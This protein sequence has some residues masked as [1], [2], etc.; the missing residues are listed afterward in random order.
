MLVAVSGGVDSMVMLDLIMK[1][2]IYFEVLHINHQTRGIDNLKDLMCVQ[3]K[4][5]DKNIK[6]HVFE[7]N[8]NSG[9]FQSE[10]RKF[11]LEMAKK[12]I[13]ENNLSAL[14]YA[15]HKDDQIENI[16]MNKDK[17]SPK[18][19]NR[20]T[21]YEELKIYRPLLEVYKANIYE[22]AEKNNVVFNEDYS[23]F[24]VKYKRNYFRNNMISKMTIDEKDEVYKREDKYRELYELVEVDSSITV[25]TLVKMPKTYTM[26]LL[27][28]MIKEKNKE[29]NVSK[30]L[31]NDILLFINQNKNGQLSISDNLIIRVSYGKILIESIS[32]ENIV[33]S[34]ILK[35]GENSFN[36]IDFYNNNLSGFIRT[37]KPG[38]K[39]EIKNG[40]KKL[41]RLFIDN[42][43]DVKERSKWPIVVDENDEIIWIPKLWRNKDEID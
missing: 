19:M 21:L 7:Y 30:S 14:V 41:S 34:A 24:E 31:I 10:A 8:H 20:V 40:H 39:V 38:D 27:Y 13:A 11:R 6:L 42:K 5:K 16:L 22:Y 3:D 35:K 18:I 4:I 25:D 2:D 12:V 15:H 33:D 26:I 29:V 28:K 23:N 37:R 36:G 32:L 1:S 17:V 43:I 9:N